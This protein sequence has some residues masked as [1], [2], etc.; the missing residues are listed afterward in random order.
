MLNATPHQPTPTLSTRPDGDMEVLAQSP[1]AQREATP[2]P[3]RH[4]VPY[5]D[6]LPLCGVL[7]PAEGYDDDSVPW[8]TKADVFGLYHIY[9]FGKPS[10]TL[11]AAFTLLHQADS[12][13]IDHEVIRFNPSLP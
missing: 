12:S 3:V 8:R 2:A 13:T 1:H 11:D 10:Y 5:Q 9:R 4:R 6:V 7:E